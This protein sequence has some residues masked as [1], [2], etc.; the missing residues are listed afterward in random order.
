[1][2]SKFSRY[3]FR[4]TS[5]QHLWKAWSKGEKVEEKCLSKES[6]TGSHFIIP[7]SLSLF[8]ILF[9][10]N[11]RYDELIRFILK[12][13]ELPHGESNTAVRVPN[14][15]ISHEEG[16]AYLSSLLRTLFAII[17]LPFSLHPSVSLSLS[18]SLC[19]SLSPPPPNPPTPLFLSL[20]LH[21]PLSLSSSLSL[22]I[23]LSLSL[24]PSLSLSLS[25][26]PSLTTG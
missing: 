3:G 5:A 17:A 7:L 26:P 21:F 2:P 20:S 13:V 9:I 8:F 6:S 25:L 10:L 19:L 11:Q 18:L 15:T 1:M 4:V 24:S 14:L 23:S 16:C 22:S 12:A